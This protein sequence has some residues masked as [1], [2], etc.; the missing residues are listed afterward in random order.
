MR[1]KYVFNQSTWKE[2]ERLCGGGGGKM[3]EEENA[4]QGV[5]S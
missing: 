4:L 1:W 3:A 2:E 5:T